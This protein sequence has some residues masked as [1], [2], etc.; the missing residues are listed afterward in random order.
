MNGETKDRRTVISEK[1][2]RQL[3][4]WIMVSVIEITE[5]S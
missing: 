1:L 4:K 3:D 5:T 2:Y